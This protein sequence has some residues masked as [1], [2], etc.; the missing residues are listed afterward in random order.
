MRNRLRREEKGKD[1]RK[2]IILKLLK[3]TVEV[4]EKYHELLAIRSSYVPSCYSYK[5]TR[6]NLSMPVPS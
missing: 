3:W 6:R 1:T 5:R 4:V 2:M